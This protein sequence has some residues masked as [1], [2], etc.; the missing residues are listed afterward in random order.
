MKPPSGYVI[1]DAPWAPDSDQAS[2]LWNGESYFTDTKLLPGMPERWIRPANCEDIKVLQ[3]SLERAN[4][5]LALIAEWTHQ[6]GANLKP[7]SADTYGDGMRAAQET[8]ASIIVSNIIV[9]R[10]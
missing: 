6:K 9:S 3:E 10:T 4:K 2:V 7:R 8:V 5:A 1:C